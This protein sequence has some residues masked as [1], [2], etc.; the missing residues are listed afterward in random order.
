MVPAIAFISALRF[1]DIG[2]I[3]ATLQAF[4]L[5]LKIIDLKIK[6]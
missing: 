5:L 6:N 3:R 2:S 1:E 4:F